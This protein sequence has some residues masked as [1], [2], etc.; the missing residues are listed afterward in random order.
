MNRWNKRWTLA[1]IFVIGLAA[2]LALGTSA[3]QAQEKKKF[4]IYLSMSFSGGGWLT[5]ASN[6]VKA[7]AATPP[8]DKMVDLQEVITGPIRSRRLPPSRT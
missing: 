5:A 8:Y 2:L 4:K 6:A 1:R 7:L 3:L